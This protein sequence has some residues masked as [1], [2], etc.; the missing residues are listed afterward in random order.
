MRE[1][2][3]NKRGPNA[4]DWSDTQKNLAFK[5]AIERKS[6]EP[7]DEGFE[8]F[9]MRRGTALEPEARQEYEKEFGVFVTRVGFVMTD[10][11]NFGASLDGTID[12][13]GSQEIKCYLQPMKLRAIHTTGDISMVMDQCQ[14][15]LWI[16][17]RK[18]MDF[19]LYCPA[20]RSIG[21]QLWVKR[22]YRDDNYIE[23]LE[24]DLWAF[25]SLIDE[26]DRILSLPY[27]SSAFEVQPR[28]VVEKASKRTATPAPI[29]QPPVAPVSRFA[30]LSARI[31][32]APS[33]ASCDLI[34]DGASDLDAIEYAALVGK[35]NERFPAEQ[36]A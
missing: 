28:V 36:A 21:K 34:L 13:D 14:G 1:S 19:C 4:G 6:G 8:T 22:I 5:Y 18:W 29:A 15:G 31:A 23:A 11:G 7:L 10:D 30:A 3:R 24:A 9:F 33:R 26:Y 20:L 35:A 27:D 16:S 32:A 12:N 17:G 2:A 25:K